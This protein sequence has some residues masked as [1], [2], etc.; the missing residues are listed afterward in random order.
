MTYKTANKVLRPVGVELIRGDG[1]HY[2]VSARHQHQIGQSVM[3]YRLNHLNIQ[4]WVCAARYA[5]SDHRKNGFIYRASKQIKS[6][7]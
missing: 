2:F 3:V 6:S 7:L 1:Y 5:I 4:R